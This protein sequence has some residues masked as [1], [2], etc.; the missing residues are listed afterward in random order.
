MSLK[1]MAKNITLPVV[2]AANLTA[3]HIMVVASKEVARHY[4]IKQ[5]DVK[6]AMKLTSRSSASHLDTVI[7]A[8]SRLLTPYHF[9]FT[10]TIVSK[11]TPTVT[12]KKGNKQILKHA[13]VAKIGKNPVLNVWYYE[14]G[15]PHIGKN[16]RTLRS[17]SVPQMIENPKVVAVINKDI[18]TSGFYEKKF[19]HEFDFISAKAGFK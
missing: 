19:I 6:K 4:T 7:R 14:A 18:E 8:E 16:L 11:A 12:I 10:P 5:R 1:T 13:F 15:K 2:R 3:N 9:K 17:V